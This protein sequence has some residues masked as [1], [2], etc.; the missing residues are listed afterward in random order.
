MM[1]GIKR[2]D[3]KISISNQHHPTVWQGTF[4]HLSIAFAVSD[5]DL[6]FVHV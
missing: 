6:L 5:F 4:S 1:L 3:K 2:M